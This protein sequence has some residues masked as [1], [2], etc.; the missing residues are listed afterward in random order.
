MTLNRVYLIN[1]HIF[2]LVEDHTLSSPGYLPGKSPTVMHAALRIISPSDPT[3]NE[4]GMMDDTLSFKDSSNRMSGA[5]GG[6]N[7]DKDNFSDYVNGDDPAAHNDT[8][9]STF[10]VGGLMVKNSMFDDLL[11]ERKLE[12]FNDPE[13]MALLSS[14]MQQSKNHLKTD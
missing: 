13:V 5:E 11:N 1:R 6:S 7:T 2:Y 10:M 14:V 4:D 9:E 12:L 8:V 3:P